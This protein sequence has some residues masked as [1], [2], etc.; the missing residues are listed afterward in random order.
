MNV[1]SLAWE[2]QR[3]SLKSRIGTGMVAGLAICSLSVSSWLA[4]VV[5]GGAWMFY[6]RSQDLSEISP[7]LRDLPDPGAM[8]DSYV[9]LAVLACAFLLPALVSLTSQAA[10]LGASGR[11]QRLAAMRLLG[12]SARQITGI[13]V[14]ETGFQAV[15]GIVIGGL[16][17]LLTAPLGSRLSF[18]DNPL[19]PTELLL[20]WWG[21]V[22][23]TAVLLVLALASSAWGMQ[24]VRVSPLGVARREMPRALR[25]WR[26][27]M[28]IIVLAGG[29]V[30]LRRLPLSSNSGFLVSVFL[31]LFVMISVLNL[32]VPFLLQLWFR[33]AALLPGAANFVGFRKVSTDARAAWRRSSA[34]A[35]Y[36]VLVGVLV[37]SP[38]GAGSVTSPFTQDPTR[39]L[40]FNDVISGIML[41]IAFG[42]IIAA[43]STLLG[44]ASEVYERADLTRALSRLGVPRSFHIRVALRQI[45]GPIILVSLVGFALGAL[46]MFVVLGSLQEVNIVAR[47]LNAVIY[48]VAGWALTALAMCA[49]E[50]LRSTVLA[51]DARA[52]K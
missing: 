48:L 25:W 9:F 10:V 51:D 40:W 44:Q 12:L 35:F 17:S 46:M 52:Q 29:F 47:T 39:S 28:M 4:F 20:P 1:V 31:L 6:R 26:L 15:V 16:A 23:V 43:V 7:A 3:S 24:R 33:L 34:T 14:V 42:F 11:E 22:V 21:Y 49:V 50:P 38:K 13:T 2:L 32:G 41:T 5:A 8:L 37:L 19:S 18:Q 30:A 45:M 27:V 36:G